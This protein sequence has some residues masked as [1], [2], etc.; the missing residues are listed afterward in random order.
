MICIAKMLQGGRGKERDS[1]INVKRHSFNER[2]RGNFG[3]TETIPSRI[4]LSSLL[5]AAGQT[6]I[7]FRRSEKVT[8]KLLRAKSNSSISISFSLSHPVL[9]PSGVCACG[10]PETVGETSISTREKIV[11]TYLL[12]FSLSLGV[13]FQVFCVC[14]FYLSWAGFG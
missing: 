8:S 3:W 4:L 13:S 10:P 7:G 2:K 5:G 12:L 6:Q 14:H 11:P 9:A 1:E